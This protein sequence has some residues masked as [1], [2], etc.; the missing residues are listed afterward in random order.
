MNVKRHLSKLSQVRV[1]QF[2]EGCFIY[3]LN[4]YIVSIHK[5]CP[6]LNT[7]EL[8]DCPSK[9]NTSDLGK[10][11]VDVVPMDIILQSVK[12]SFNKTMK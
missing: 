5:S 6:H 7:K 4:T 2:E 12:M 8:Q 10:N 1:G 3:K 9:T 11:V